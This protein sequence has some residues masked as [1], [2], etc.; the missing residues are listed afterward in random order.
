MGEPS[1]SIPAEGIGIDHQS[2]GHTNIVSHSELHGYAKARRCLLSAV[3]QCNL[4]FFLL[5]DVMENTN[6]SSVKDPG[7]L[8][9]YTV[10]L[11]QLL[12]RDREYGP[13]FQTILD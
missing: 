3:I 1:L 13:R 12:V 9:K 11:L 8:K 5:E 2:S 6:L 4:P 10:E 7:S